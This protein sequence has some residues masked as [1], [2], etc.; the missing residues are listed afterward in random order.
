MLE[1]L[2]PIYGELGGDPSE[3]VMVKLTR[4]TTTMLPF[5]STTLTLASRRS[6]P[7]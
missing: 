5:T 3:L 1:L 4:S 7:E 2:S 6:S